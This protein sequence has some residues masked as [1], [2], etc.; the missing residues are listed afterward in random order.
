M[1]SQSLLK[2][3]EPDVQEP[4]L[5][6]V[7]MPFNM[8]EVEHATSK[9]YVEHL[10]RSDMPIVAARCVPEYLL[11][12]W[13]SFDERKCR[14][15]LPTDYVFDPIDVDMPFSNAEVAALTSEAYVVALG[16]SDMPT[17]NSGVGPR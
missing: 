3:E 9:T 16:R 14:A 13:R 17:I 7:D 15:A 6:D 1:R 4:F 8:E 12:G 11:Q 10:T 5:I 2:I